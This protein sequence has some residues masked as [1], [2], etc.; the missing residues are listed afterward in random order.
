MTTFDLAGALRRIRRLADCSQ[1]DLA[2]ALGVSKSA[3]A[4]AESGQRDL[5]VTA[6]SRA[7]A[8]AE[9]R[10]ALLDPDGAEVRGMSA[11]AVRDLGG[12]R[13]PAHLDTR[14]SDDG[15]WWYEPRRD[16]PEPWFTFTRDRRARDAERARA[17]A[18]P[19][20]HHR[21]RPE[22][23]PDQRRAAR[24]RAAELRRREEYRRRFAAGELPPLEPFDCACPPECEA[25]DDYTG[26][27]VHAAECPCS[28]DVG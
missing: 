19:E 28:C 12:R 21:W 25:L 3:I 6:L 14:P 20:D 24:R 2:V 7:A 13:F 9:L 8:L 22:D 23:S 27:P 5:P 18:A 11:E 1:R 10:L 15:L 17:A 26:R 4:A 16:R